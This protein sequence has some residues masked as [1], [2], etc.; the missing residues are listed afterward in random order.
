MYRRIIYVCMYH[1]VQYG[2][3][4][5]RRRPQGHNYTQYVLLGILDI[6]VKRIRHENDDAANILL[7][8]VMDFTLWYRNLSPR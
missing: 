1:G 8:W 6:S 2:G 3:A 5:Q 4:C 7:L